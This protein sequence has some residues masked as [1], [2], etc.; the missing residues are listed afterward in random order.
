M[1]CIRF[2]IEKNDSWGYRLE[3]LL[4]GREVWILAI[5]PIRPLRHQPMWLVRK[6]TDKPKA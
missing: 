5:R 6:G 1:R 2:S 3:C 4:K